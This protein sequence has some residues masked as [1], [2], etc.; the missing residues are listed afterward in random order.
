M[1]DDKIRKG[2]LD[3]KRVRLCWGGFRNMIPIVAVWRSWQRCWSEGQINEVLRRARL[4]LG[5]VTS[6]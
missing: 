1:F 4:V 6:L 2:C 5:W 3:L